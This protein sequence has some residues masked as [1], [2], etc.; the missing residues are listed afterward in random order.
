MFSSSRFPYIRPF[1]I[2]LCRL[3]GDLVVR[4]TKQADFGGFY[5]LQSCT[6]TQTQTFAD[7]RTA[8]TYGQAREELLYFIFEPFFV[9]VPTML[10]TFWKPKL[11]RGDIYLYIRAFLRVRSCARYTLISILRV[12][13]NADTSL[14]SVFLYPEFFLCA[15]VCARELERTRV[16]ACV[17]V[18]TGVCAFRGTDVW[19]E[20]SQGINNV[21]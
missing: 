3:F 15:C 10:S 8:P 12:G 11:S 18:C 14:I 21:T 2:F 1:L 16:R 20:T 17:R 6:Y 4:S 9:F 7:P 13:S 19:Q 5:L